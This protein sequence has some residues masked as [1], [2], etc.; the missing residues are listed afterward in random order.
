M[1]LGN[2][3]KHSLRGTSI[4]STSVGAV[5]LFS[6]SVGLTGLRIWILDFS[7]EMSILMS[8]SGL[9]MSKSMSTTL[10]LSLTNCLVICKFCR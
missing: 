8:M 9:I 6:W 1:H 5:H 7:L 4:P 2:V 10:Y 3:N